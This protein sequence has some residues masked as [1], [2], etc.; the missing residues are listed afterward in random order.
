LVP[1]IK[2]ISS[3]WSRK[4]RDEKRGLHQEGRRETINGTTIEQPGLT[5]TLNSQP[6]IRSIKVRR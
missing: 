6:V 2:S 4:S 1:C 3:P 5:E